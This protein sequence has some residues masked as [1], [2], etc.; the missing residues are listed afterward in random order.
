MLAEVLHQLPQDEYQGIWPFLYSLICLSLGVGWLVLV[1][2]VGL[3]LKLREW[4]QRER[5]R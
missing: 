5:A 3:M 1:G 4:Y 2:I